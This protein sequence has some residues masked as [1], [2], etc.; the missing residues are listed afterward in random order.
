MAFVKIIHL[1]DLL[2]SVTFMKCQQTLSLEKCPEV[3]PGQDFD[4]MTTSAQGA[5]TVK[6][7]TVQTL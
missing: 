7:N 4:I 5:A 2:D 3:R 6:M 1:N